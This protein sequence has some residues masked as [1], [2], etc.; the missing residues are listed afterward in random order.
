MFHM[1][2]L[3]LLSYYLGIEMRQGSSGINIPQLAYALKLLEKAGMVGSNP[4]HVPMEPR[5]KL[6]K[7]NT[8]PTTD[9]SIVGNLQYLVQTRPDVTNHCSILFSHP[10]FL[11]SSVHMLLSSSLS[12]YQGR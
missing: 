7:H 9:E 1:F 3:R 11:S 8:T 4:Y 6:S 12:S 5:F 10:S 2:D